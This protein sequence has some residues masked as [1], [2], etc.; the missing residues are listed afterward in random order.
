MDFGYKVT[1]RAR[2][3][4]L[5]VWKHIAKDNHDS[6]NR[7]REELMLAAKSLRTFPQRHGG[8]VKRPNIR[9][10]PYGNYLIF[11]KINEDTH[12]VEILRFW[13][14]AREQR[15]LRLKEEASCYGDDLE[16]RRRQFASDEGAVIPGDEILLQQ[17]Q[18]QQ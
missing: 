12:V 4:L 3:D 1:A 17:Y 6:A 10:L 16:L 18:S 9:K 2:N 7:F 15:Q 8:F 5:R 13:H 11:Y 14:A